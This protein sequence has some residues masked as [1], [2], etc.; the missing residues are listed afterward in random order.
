MH[1]STESTT[2]KRMGCTFAT[3]SSTIHAIE[4]DDKKVHA[5]MHDIDNPV[6]ATGHI[7]PNT[8]VPPEPCG[9]ASHEGIANT[10]DKLIPGAEGGKSQGPIRAVCICNAAECGE[11]VYKYEPHEPVLFKRVSVFVND[12]GFCCMECEI[13]QSYYSRVMSRLESESW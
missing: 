5:I 10:G 2:T 3:A 12:R 6:D 7:H 13:F 9:A 1:V 8:H 4:Y 11:L